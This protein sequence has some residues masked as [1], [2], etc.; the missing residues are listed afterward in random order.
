MAGEKAPGPPLFLLVIVS[1]LVAIAGTWWF[2]V[3]RA[4]RNMPLEA[5]AY[6]ETEAIAT[7]RAIHGTGAV[8]ARGDAFA[9]R[10]YAFRIHREGDGKSWTAVALPDGGPTLPEGRSF[11]VGR[12]G[13][14]EQAPP[15]ASAAGRTWTPVD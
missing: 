3:D 2:L 8:D 12:D 11:R 1:L 13:K 9:S 7:L 5:V 6:H 4:F 14:V 15:P 10:G